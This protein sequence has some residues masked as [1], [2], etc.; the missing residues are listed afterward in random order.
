MKKHVYSQVEHLER[1]GVLFDCVQYYTED[2]NGEDY[3][4]ESQID[5]NLL[6]RQDSY[7]K[8]IGLLTSQEIK[9]IRETYHLSQKD[10][11]SIL[12]LGEINVAR[13]ETKTVQS[14]TIN[15]ILVRAKQDP[16]WFFERFKAYSTNLSAPKVERSEKAIV[17]ATDSTDVLTAYWDDYLQAIYLK[18]RAPS[19]KNGGCQ[20]NLMA[21]SSIVSLAKEKI[22]DLY[23]TKL[24]KILF[25]CDFVSY[26]KQGHGLTGLVYIHAPHGALPKGYEEIIRS[27]LFDVEEKVVFPHGEECLSYLISTRQ[28]NTLSANDTALVRDILDAIR[29]KYTKDLCDYMHSEDAY[30]KTKDGQI[31][32]YGY[33]KTLSL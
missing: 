25:Y 31:I 15:D 12:G 21:I 6:L 28:K 11:A 23:K 16:L 26:R 4:D 17:D 24:A 13:Y 14:K 2:E 27:P 8:A 22:S 18:Y 19:S 33:S 32:D 7:R 5:Q 20:L 9:G 1:N 3:V 29:Q 30:T 10:F